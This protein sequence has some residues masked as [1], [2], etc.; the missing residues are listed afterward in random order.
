MYWDKITEHSTNSALPF[1]IPKLRVHYK[2]LAS[3]RTRAKPMFTSYLLVAA[4]TALPLKRQ[5]RPVRLGSARPSKNPFITASR[6]GAYL[7]ELRS[8]NPRHLTVLIQPHRVRLILLLI[9]YQALFD[10]PY[11][12]PRPRA[13]LPPSF[14]AVHLNTVSA[15]SVSAC[16]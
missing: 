13:H 7:I 6:E 5:D 8:H 2:C 9:V 12:C 10:R 1:K 11:R 16:R 14:P 15:G 3:I 4:C